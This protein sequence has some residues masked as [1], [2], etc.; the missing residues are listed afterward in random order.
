[1]L[2]ECLIYHLWVSVV[3]DKEFDTIPHVRQVARVVT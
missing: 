2:K 1:M 3:P